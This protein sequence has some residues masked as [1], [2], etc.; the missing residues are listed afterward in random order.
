M[1]LVVLCMPMLK[2][3]YNFQRYFH[4]FEIACEAHVSG[5][6][7]LNVLCD[8][9]CVLFLFVWGGVHLLP[10]NILDAASKIPYPLFHSAQNMRPCLSS[11]A[12]NCSFITVHCRIRRPGGLGK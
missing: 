6:A 11:F 7:A 4:L 5:V 3:D 10:A 8:V 9:V 12:R 2:F 1:R